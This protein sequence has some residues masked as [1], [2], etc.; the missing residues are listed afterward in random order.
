MK[1]V[2][3]TLISL[4]LIYSTTVYAFSSFNLSFNPNIFTRQSINLHAR[5]PFLSGNWKLNPSTQE[6]AVTLAQDIVKTITIDSPESDVA[7]FIP[8]VFIDSVKQAVEGSKVMVGAETSYP[9]PNGAFT[10]AISSPMLQSVGVQWVLAGHS[11]RRAVFHETDEDIN[12]QCKSILQQG[13]NVMLCIGESESEYE[14]GLAGPVCTIQLQNCLAGISKEEMSHVAIAYEPVW[15]IG[16]G[17]VATPKTAQTVHSL[18]RG[19]LRNIYGGNVSENTRILYGGSVTPANV[20]NLM[21]M[22]DVDGALVGGASLKSDTFGKI[23][24]FQKK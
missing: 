23:L 13:L 24:N 12:A 11:E 15:A 8:Y 16:T 10:G 19:I 6:E 1:K 4:F 5:K 14:K 9:Q 22:P 2:I 20:D 21:N 3:S 17:K 7:L 18:C